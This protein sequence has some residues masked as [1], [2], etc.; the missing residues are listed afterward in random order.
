M[1]RDPVFECSC[2]SKVIKTTYEAN[3]HPLIDCLLCRKCYQN[4]GSGDFS[5]FEDGV[6]DAGDDNYC[7][8][9]CDGG[10]LFGCMNVKNGE[11]CHYAFCEDCIKR[12]CPNDIVL[13]INKMSEEEQKRVRWMC[14]AC[15]KSKI[16]DLRKEAKEAMESLNKNGSKNKVEPSPS[17]A[18]KKRT[19]EIQP[20]D[21]PKPQQQPPQRPQPPQKPQPQQAAKSQAQPPSKPQQQP[22]PQPPMQ[23]PPKPQQQP[24]KLQPQE[25]QKQQQQQQQQPK[26]QQQQPK[27]QQQQQQQ[28]KP[29]PPQLQ[30]SRPQPQQ[31]ANQPQ[32]VSQTRQTRQQPPAPVSVP[33]PQPASA[34]KPATV[35]A[36][37]SATPPAPQPLQPQIKSTP[38]TTA[39]KSKAD[40]L[41]KPMPLSK[42]RALLGNSVILTDLP[43][44]EKPTK[45]NDTQNGKSSTIEIIETN[46][47]DNSKSMQPHSRKE[48]GELPVKKLPG[49]EIVLSKSEL[50][51]RLDVH[52]QTK[53]DCIE[54]IG[55][56]IKT[57]IE[58]MLSKDAGDKSRKKMINL[59][60]E[61]L[62]KPIQEFV[63]I[64]GDLKILNQSL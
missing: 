9:C 55:I 13:Q 28:P 24:P 38:S 12:N 56:S 5:N 20:Q 41:N 42:K 25:Q 37:A 32:Q 52:L 8:W 6:D 51:R 4:Y 45:T 36:P 10:Q 19:G 21:L 48:A 3:L 54:E 15:D 22:K 14:Y 30:P 33:Q 44:N 57:V 62:Q 39:V 40:L 46:R 27:P 53:D 29:Q 35:P 60:I 26:P 63:S 43:I 50:K 2:C 7:R 64:L 58:M 11:R 31:P 18:K 49:K 23:P 1:P 16:A 59:K 47:K 61:S 34:P 17:P